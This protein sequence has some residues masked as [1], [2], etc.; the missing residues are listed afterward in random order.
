M[1]NLRFLYYT[2]NQL[3]IEGVRGTAFFNPCFINMTKW[4][5]I[6]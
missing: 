6:D 1:D 4:I 5:T 2:H 3:L